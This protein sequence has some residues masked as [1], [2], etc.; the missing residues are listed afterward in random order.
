MTQHEFINRV[1]SLY[2]IDRVKLPELS[3]EQWLEFRD[4]PPRYLIRTDKDQADA[5]MREV[6]KRQ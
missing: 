6:E 1:R 4:D 3:D 2:N 5:I